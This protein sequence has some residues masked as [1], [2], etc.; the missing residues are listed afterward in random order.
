M[1]NRRSVYTDV[2]LAALDGDEAAIRRSLGR[3]DES[4]LS[5]LRNCADAI[6]ELAEQQR[7]RLRHARGL[8]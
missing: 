4:S 2:L 3:L 6:N 7:K 8:A 5:R 1:A